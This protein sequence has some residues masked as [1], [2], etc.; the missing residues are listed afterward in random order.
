MLE[1]Q[2]K[3]PTKEELELRSKAWTE[4]TDAQKI[5]RQRDVIKDLQRTVGFMNDRLFRLESNFN[6][7][8]HTEKG[9]VVALMH[10]GLA[11][12]LSQGAKLANPN[13]F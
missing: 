7:H 13:Y 5:E 4:L 9:I 10:N 12:A 11:G 1:E 6:Q 3:S 8:S 2:L